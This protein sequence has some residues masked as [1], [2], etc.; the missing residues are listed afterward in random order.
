M[1]SLCCMYFSNIQKMLL[2]LENPASLSCFAERVLVTKLHLEYGSFSI[3]INFCSA[4]MQPRTSSRLG[5]CSTTEL[6]HQP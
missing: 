1:G 4:G 3:F 2:F 5:K 6:H